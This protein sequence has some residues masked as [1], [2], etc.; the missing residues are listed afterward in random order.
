M[1]R[2][3]AMGRNWPGRW[4]AG[5][6]AL[7]L[8]LGGA[9]VAGA[10]EGVV[11]FSGV[12]PPSVALPA[13]PDDSIT[14]AAEASVQVASP[15]WDLPNLDHPRVDYWVERFTTDKRDEFSG[16]LSR[17]GAYAPMISA[18]LTERG[19]PQDLLYLA[20]IESGFKPRAYSRAHASGLW[21]FIRG[22]GERYGLEVNNA[23]DE[24]NDPEK[25]T[26]AALAYLGD[27]HDRFGSWYLAAAGYNTGEN[28]VGRIMRQ[29]T[30]S[31]RGE[32]TDYYRIWSRL[33]RETRDYVPL[34]VAAARISKDPARYG[35]GEVRI[36]EPLVYD[37]VTV[38]PASQLAAIARAADTT[39][40]EI[41]RLNPHFKL[42]RTRNDMPVQ[43][44]VPVGG[45]AMFAANWTRVRED[46]RLASAEAPKKSETRS[47]RV[48]RGDNL[49]LIA[50]RHGVSIAAIRRENGLRGDRIRA[51]ATLRIP[52]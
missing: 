36:E 33:P 9:V 26:D 32:E 5:R 14:V 43:V 35:F 30:G 12:E 4:I 24:R 37:A 48:R 1:R 42:N 3:E 45:G 10:V 20:M 41:K 13:T 28:R 27:L 15:T 46:T 25:A 49:T 51:G 40:D 7:G 38:E 2:I 8:A 17:S 44:R 31:E 11:R 39:V 21:Q 22:T 47:Y 6:F 23:V 29:V 18:K 16:F 19:M 52:G 50:R 34:M